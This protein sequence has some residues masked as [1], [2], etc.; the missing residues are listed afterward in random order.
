MKTTNIGAKLGRLQSGI[1]AAIASLAAA[2][3]LD[4][5]VMEAAMAHDTPQRR[6]RYAGL[7]RPA[8]A[9]LRRAAYNGTL[10]VRHA[11]STDQYWRDLYAKR[12]LAART[13]RIENAINRQQAARKFAFGQ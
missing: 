1:G 8:G 10:T 2:R 9:K 12:I 6:T 4:K 13:K 3:G 7:A 5:A 11:S